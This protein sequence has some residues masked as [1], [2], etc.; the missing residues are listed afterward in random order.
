MEAARRDFS[1]RPTDRDGCSR[2][3]INPSTVFGSRLDVFE[4]VSLSTAFN[5]IR[6]TDGIGKEC[7]ECISTS[8]SRIE[9]LQDA[10]SV[11]RG[12]IGASEGIDHA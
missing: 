2:C 8:L 7:E 12:D 5:M 4:A 1:L 6:E 9:Y 10:L 3:P 11:L